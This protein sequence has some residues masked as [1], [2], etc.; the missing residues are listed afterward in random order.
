MTGS[1]SSNSS[2]DSARR[3]FAVA[4]GSNMTSGAIFNCF[5]V[6]RMR[7]HI[8]DV[9]S[10]PPIATK[11]PAAAFRPAAELPAPLLLRLRSVR[12]PRCM[13]LASSDILLFPARTFDSQGL[14]QSGT[15]RGL[16]HT[17]LKI[18][19][20]EGLLAMWRPGIGA[21]MIREIF[22]GGCQFGT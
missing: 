7:L 4:A 21:T 1:N 11:R 8:Q 5:D 20:E 12:S 18:T 13:C 9:R 2:G 3:E 19:K 10:S 6:C 14:G 22:Y 15:Y 17:M 16:A